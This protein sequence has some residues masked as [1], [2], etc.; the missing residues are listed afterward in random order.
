MATVDE[1]EIQ[2]IYVGEGVVRVRIARPSGVDAILIVTIFGGESEEYRMLATENIPVI[3]S[4]G[5]KFV[6]I[7]IP[8]TA[9][10]IKVKVWSC[11]SIMEPLV[12]C[13]KVTYDGYEWEEL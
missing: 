10:A 11:F 13:E 2:G 8:E 7:N 5:N 12:N 1:V 6:Y 3:I 9:T 4:S